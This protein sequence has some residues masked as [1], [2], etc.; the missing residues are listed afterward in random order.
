MG[1]KLKDS[2]QLT[3]FKIPF[4]YAIYTGP[5]VIHADSFLIG[6]YS[7]VYSITENYSTVLIQNKEGKI[8]PV[9]VLWTT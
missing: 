1:K 9:G 7:V 3:A 5:N 4:G 6:D 2:Y 8:I